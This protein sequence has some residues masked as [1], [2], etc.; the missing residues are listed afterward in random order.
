MVM[1]MVA[2]KLIAM[3]SGQASFGAVAADAS[4]AAS[5]LG[6]AILGLAVG[7]K[8][9]YTAPTGREIP[10]EIVKVATYTGQ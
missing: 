7:A 3:I 9:S 8:T 6:A 10:V 5:P 1:P 2:R 4:A